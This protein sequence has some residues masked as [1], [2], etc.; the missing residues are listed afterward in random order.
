MGRAALLILVAALV[1]ATCISCTPSD[2]LTAEPQ[3]AEQSSDATAP[4]ETASDDHSE[5]FATWREQP[6]HNHDRQMAMEMA[7]GGYL[8]GMSFGEVTEALGPYDA[9]G[10]PLQPVTPGEEPPGV[11][12]GIVY[13]IEG[14][15][16]FDIKFVD[17][18]ATSAEYYGLSS[19]EELDLSGEWL[20]EGGIRLE[21]LE[22]QG[23]GGLIRWIRPEPDA[24][25]RKGFG[26]WWML[27]PGRLVFYDMNFGEPDVASVYLYQKG[28]GR[29]NLTW[30]DE[31]ID[32]TAS[33]MQGRSPVSG[34]WIA[35]ESQPTLSLVRP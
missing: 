11:T 2:N 3:E 13:E 8:I 9:E 14:G 5:F 12:G 20:V 4:A 19:Q 18:V 32:P 34:E 21:K 26:S 16:A 6:A 22:L 15:G 33:G 17:G 27:E 24:A 31:E 35:G 1:C 28:D 30:I 29:L 7:D 25:L 10:I 23:G